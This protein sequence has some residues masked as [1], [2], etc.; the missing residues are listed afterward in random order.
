MNSK[1]T[2]GDRK[3]C[4][5]SRVQPGTVVEGI[6]SKAIQSKNSEHKSV[7][8]KS[9]KMPHNSGPRWWAI[10]LNSTAG[11]G[12]VCLK[13]DRSVFVV[14]VAN[15][16]MAFC[17]WQRW[18]E[19]RLHDDRRCTLN[20]GWLKVSGSVLSLITHGP[21][22]PRCSPIKCQVSSSTPERLALMH[23]NSLSWHWHP[24]RDW[25]PNC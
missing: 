5:R 7:L 17:A 21:I 10:V 3:S 14:G 16:V 20:K 18:K 15:R 1:M 2:Y 23:I 4:L 9:V 8:Y 11:T 22:S 24:G 25:G 13:E 19:S 6:S 12:R